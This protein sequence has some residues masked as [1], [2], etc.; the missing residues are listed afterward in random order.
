MEQNKLFEEEE[1]VKVGES[2]VRFGC[3]K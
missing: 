3:V 1:K 2:E